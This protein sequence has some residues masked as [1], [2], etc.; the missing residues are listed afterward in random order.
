[1]IIEIL[2]RGTELMPRLIPADWD[3]LTVIRFEQN[4]ITVLFKNGTVTFTP[5]ETPDAVA[6]IQIP[7]KRF[8]DMIDCTI[9][10]MTTWR[11]LAEPS[12]TDR[13]YI[14][15]GKGAKLIMLI[16]LLSRTYKANNEFKQ[17]FDNYKNTLI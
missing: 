1:M 17:M 4:S 12:P 3:E 11:E 6:V 14:L 5:G 16:D 9:D 10:F 8:C 7:V 2:A 13:R 15:K